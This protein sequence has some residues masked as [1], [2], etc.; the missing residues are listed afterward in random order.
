M[1]VV[2]PEVAV[3]HAVYDGVNKGTISGTDELDSLTKRIYSRY[4]IWPEKH[5]EMKATW[6]NIRLMYEDPFYDINYVYGVLLALK[7]YE[8]YS[9]DPQDFALRYLA[10]MRNGFD[11]PPAI[12]LRRFLDI[13]LHD[14]RLVSNAL[15]VLERKVNLLEESYQK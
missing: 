3:E 13:D 14:P 10:L 1:F 6:M 2:A 5:D 4:S 9:R 12:L 15:S 8:M 11:A 7:F